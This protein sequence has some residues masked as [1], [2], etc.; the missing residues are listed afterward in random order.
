MIDVI[1]L[2]SF[3]N[4]FMSLCRMLLFFIIFFTADIMSSGAGVL[5]DGATSQSL[6]TQLWM[7]DLKRTVNI[8]I[9]TV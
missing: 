6:G 5:V 9:V 1:S 4:T 8:I 3:L 2:S 7:S